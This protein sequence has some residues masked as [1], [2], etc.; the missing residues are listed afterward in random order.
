MSHR[1]TIL[2]AASASAR[3]SA[4]DST[5]AHRA[6]SARTS[7]PG[8]PNLALGKTET[9]NRTDALAA[10]A[11]NTAI[12]ARAR[13]MG[14]LENGQQRLENRGDFFF[15]ASRAAFAGWSAPRASNAGAEDGSARV[16]RVIFGDPSLVARVASEGSGETSAESDPRLSHALGDAALPSGD[17]ANKGEER[18]YGCAFSAPSA[19]RTERSRFH[20]SLPLSAGVCASFASF[21]SFASLASVAVTTVVRLGRFF[22]T[23]VLA[24][25][26]RRRPLL[27]SIV[28]AFVG[29]VGET[30]SVS[31]SR[32]RFDVLRGVV[33]LVSVTLD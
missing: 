9:A 24:S 13:E 21:A 28:G 2:F 26:G 8:S 30:A 16:S 7:T 1:E 14:A 15:A 25:A 4:A 20:A 32:P 18:A 33:T 5:S 17:A 29:D 31:A 19:K 22:F 6:A 11:P 23:V 27:S 10:N 3:R 12:A